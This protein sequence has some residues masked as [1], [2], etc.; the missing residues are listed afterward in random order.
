M[1]NDKQCEWRDMKKRNSALQLFIATHLR[2]SLDK[3]K[4]MTTRSIINAVKNNKL[5]GCVECDIH[6]PE[7]L[8]EHFKEMCLIFKNIE[9][10]REDIGELMRSYAEENNVMYQPRRS[11]IGSM[12]GDKILLATPL[13]KWYLE[14]G[15]GVT[16]IYQVMEYTPKPC[17]KPFGDA[18][19]DARRAGDADPSK[20]II[21]DTMKLVGNRYND[22]DFN[23]VFYYYNCSS[24]GKTITN[25]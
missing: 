12:K 24:Y 23:F 5:F 10:R 21:A 7:S 3:V 9:I 22:K 16:R 8:R 15:L 4:T 14:H 25:K 2:R 18:V 20:A 17:F 1:R 13:L 19:S 6:V 11:L